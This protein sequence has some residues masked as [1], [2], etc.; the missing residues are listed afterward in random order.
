MGKV[1]NQV[2][3]TILS[4]SQPH[5]GEKIEKYAKLAILTQ[6]KPLL[7]PNLQLYVILCHIG[8]KQFEKVGKLKIFANVQP[9]LQI[10]HI[11]TL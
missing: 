6:S 11:Y 2:K 1:V 7:W 10:I 5:F 4:Q 3:L 8:V 9:P